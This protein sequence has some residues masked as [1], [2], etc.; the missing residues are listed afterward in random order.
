MTKFIHLTKAN[1][2]DVLI[3]IDKILFVVEEEVGL[4]LT[5]VQVA[6]YLTSGGHKFFVRNTFKDILTQLEY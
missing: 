2:L 1:N 5:N 3:P 6:V 4:A